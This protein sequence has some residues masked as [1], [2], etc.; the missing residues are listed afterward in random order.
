[1]RICTTRIKVARFYITVMR[2]QTTRALYAPTRSG[3]PRQGI[4]PYLPPPLLV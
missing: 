2:C 4:Q 3:L 1:M